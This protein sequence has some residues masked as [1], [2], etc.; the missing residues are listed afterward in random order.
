MAF[1]TE[2][3]HGHM[4]VSGMTSDKCIGH[5]LLQSFK[6]IWNFKEQA[7]SLYL[8]FCGAPK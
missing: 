7:I 3:I 2:Y 1:Y 6:D 4:S 5:L 8:N